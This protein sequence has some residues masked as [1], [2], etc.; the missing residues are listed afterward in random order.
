MSD[1]FNVPPT[2]GTLLS[3]I[4]DGVIAVLTALLGPTKRWSHAADRRSR[5][6]PAR[7]SDHQASARTSSLSAL[8]H[9]IVRCLV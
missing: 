7:R 4:V 2:Y 3:T 8:Q 5:S 1:E 6:A 9:Q